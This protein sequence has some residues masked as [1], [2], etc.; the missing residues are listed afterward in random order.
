[1]QA[2]QALQQQAQNAMQGGPGGANPS[3]PAFPPGS[4]PPGFPPAALQNMTPQQQQQIA[5]A[6]G[7]LQ[8]GQQGQ[9]P[10]QP[11]QSPVRPGAMPGAPPIRPP[12]GVNPNEFP[13]DV[14][15]LPYLQHVNDPRWRETMQQRN[16]TMVAEVLSIAQRI[17][18]GQIRP[19]T[20]QGMQQFLVYISAVSR[21]RMAPGQS[22]QQPLPPHIQQQLQGM[23]GFPGTPVQQ[24][25]QSPQDPASGIPPAQQQRLWPQ[26][27]AGTPDTPT[28]MRPPP[29]HLPPGTPDSP[30]L[31]QSLLA[32]R[33]SG[34]D[35][36]RESTMPPPP[37]IPG[38]GA[39]PT[40]AEAAAAAASAAPPAP[41]S[42]LPVKEWEGHVRLDLPITQ[43][44]ALPVE[45]FDERED[46]TFGGK[47]PNLTDGEKENI[48]TWMERDG[49]FA[50]GILE[51]R[52]KTAAKMA[53]WVE[54]DDAQTPWW[55]Y[56]KGEPPT[57]PRSQVT[58]I[59]Q[60]DKAATRMKTRKRRDNRFTPEQF[61]AM[62]E[63]EEHLV[64]VRV[65][66]EHDHVRFCDTF[67]WNCSGES[68]N[69]DHD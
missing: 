21:N 22:P 49:E 66:L 23:P 63:V 7:Y 60:A 6:M 12:P 54:N 35:K 32:R 4:L 39:R 34:K 37:F 20:L 18:S 19:E 31:N 13:F 61:K 67:M 57:R 17:Q 36:P 26:Q 2:I 56:R 27:G 14:R 30:S 1:M 51:H 10:G 8:Q 38:H 33:A 16:P 9:Q 59:T 53:K 55:Q 25:Q 69:V 58:I 68:H 45:D 41:A 5:H 24:T 40:T 11:G 47:L 50:T 29:P 64:P 65:E 52:K 46:S 28:G 15:L 62:A 48:K 43:I 44:S 42:G 3:Q